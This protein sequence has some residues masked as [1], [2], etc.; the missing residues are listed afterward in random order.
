MD[1]FK[2]YIR[3]YGLPLCVYL[4]KHTTYKSNAKVSVEDVLNEEVP[5][6]EFERALKELGVQVRHAH[7]P[8]AKGRVERLFGT[9]Q[10]RLV[11]ELRLRDIRT[12]E[13]ANN[14][15][16]QYLPLYN[17]KFAVRPLERDNL[18]RPLP[19]GLKLDS[20]LCI[21][22]ERALRND[23]TVAYNKKLYQI[24]ERTRASKVMVHEH[25]DGSVKITYRDQALR[26]KEI[27]TRPLHE[28]KAPVIERITKRYRLPPDHPWRRFKFGIHRY[29]RGNPNL[30]PE[31]TAQGLKQGVVA[32]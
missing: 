29:E 11:K 18:H 12:I 23:F 16:T 32:T 4:D 25:I 10:D 30:R 19:K 9:L 21:K 24:E 17:R 1:S 15:L 2:G 27:T 14:F 26:F 5:L 7:S 20:V 31:N 22:A 3:K 13:V 8:Q 6:S 28:E